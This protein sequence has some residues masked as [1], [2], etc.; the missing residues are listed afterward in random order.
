[1]PL[2]LNF[3]D[4]NSGASF[5]TAIAVITQRIY[6]D[7]NGT[8]SAN[9]CIFASQELKD[10]GK[11]PVWGPQGF[12]IPANPL[13]SPVVIQGQETPLPV[14]PIAEI[15]SYLLTLDMFQGATNV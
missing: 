12:V 15:E 3:T 2:Q 9:V 13:P 4:P 1:M 5:P 7:L 6:D 10:A 14:D 11:S 8:L